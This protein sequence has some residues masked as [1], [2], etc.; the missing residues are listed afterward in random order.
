[1]IFSPA[2]FHNVNTGGIRH[3]ISGYDSILSASF[4]I[5]INSPSLPVLSS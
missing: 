5:S 1:M 4:G 2:N 3:W